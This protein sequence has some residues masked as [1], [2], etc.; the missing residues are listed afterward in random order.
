MK[1]VVV[2]RDNTDYAR[3]LTDWIRDFEHTT[4]KQVESLDPDTVDGE[5]FVRA[6]DIMEYPAIVAV[7][8]DGR[9]LKKWSGKK[10][11]QIDDVSYF[12]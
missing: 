9:V 10:L 8:D 4:G 6:R 5:I 7:A 12:A 3:E 11:P 1:V 2:W